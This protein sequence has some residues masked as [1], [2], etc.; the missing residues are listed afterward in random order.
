M[1]IQEIVSK[2]KAK[3]VREVYVQGWSLLTRSHFGSV[4]PEYKLSQALVS[5]TEIIEFWEY[6]DEDIMHIIPKTVEE[7]LAQNGRNSNKNNSKR[8]R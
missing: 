1:I 4:I 2:W 6:M 3:R 5:G 8:R 7:A